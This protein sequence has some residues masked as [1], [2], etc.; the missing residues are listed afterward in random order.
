MLYG[1]SKIADKEFPCET[2]D[3]CREWNWDTNPRFKD[4][5]QLLAAF[6]KMVE[7][8]RNPTIGAIRAGTPSSDD[9]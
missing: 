9:R 8:Q 3:V 5:P 1:Y 2:A 6:G 4:N 7:P